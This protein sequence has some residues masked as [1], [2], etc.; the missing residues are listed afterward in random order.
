MPVQETP[1][2]PTAGLP[3]VESSERNVNIKDEDE[4]VIL[5]LDVQVELLPREA[6]PRLGTV[7]TEKTACG[8]Y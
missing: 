8:S 6:L 3:P 5:G 4:K 2:L 1:F 7:A